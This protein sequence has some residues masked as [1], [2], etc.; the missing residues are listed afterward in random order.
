[1]RIVCVTCEKYMHSGKCIA[2]FC[3][4]TA[5]V[6]HVNYHKTCEGEWGGSK[7]FVSLFGGH[8]LHVVG[9][10]YASAVPTVS[11]EEITTI[12]NKRWL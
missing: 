11:L 2:C 4:C 1:M 3:I 6:V 5:L 8:F 9:G 10:Q 12:L 7:F